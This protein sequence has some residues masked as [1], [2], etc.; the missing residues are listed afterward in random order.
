MPRSSDRKTNQR[1]AKKKESLRDTSSSFERMLIEISK[2]GNT[3]R[4]FSTNRTYT[5]LLGKTATGLLLDA[6]AT[7]EVLPKEQ[8]W[9]HKYSLEVFAAFCMYFCIKKITANFSS[10][11]YDLAQDVVSVVYR[12][13][14]TRI[15]KDLEAGVECH[16][17]RNLIKRSAQNAMIDILRREGKYVLVDDLAERASGTRTGDDGPE[18][19]GFPEAAARETGGD[20]PEDDVPESIAVELLCGTCSALKKE[21]LLFI[22]ESAI[23]ETREKGI[24]TD[25]DVEN[26]CCYYQFGDGFEKLSNNE[27]AAKFDCKPP[28]VSQRRKKALQ[29]L[30]DYIQEKYAEEIEF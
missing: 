25:D 9:R 2:F 19:D 13:V 17:V 1:T 24:L 5:N 14:L 15:K 27:L 26:I 3:Y 30:R 20:A 8:R 10:I 6:A 21:R 23:E 18:D 7:T 11:D 4:S 28:T 29:K 16:F 22:V 12:K